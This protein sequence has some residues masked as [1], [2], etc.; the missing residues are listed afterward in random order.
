[1]AARQSNTALIAIHHHRITRIK[2]EEY[3][4][5]LLIGMINNGD[6]TVLSGGFST[7]ISPGKKPQNRPVGR[8][9]LL[10]AQISVLEIFIQGALDISIQATAGEQRNQAHQHCGLSYHGISAG[11]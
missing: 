11:R 5:K 10:A 2:A 4:H 9:A 8:S 3:Y 7:G 1:M 6:I